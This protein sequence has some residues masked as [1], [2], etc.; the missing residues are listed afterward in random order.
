MSKIYTSADQIDF[1]LAEISN[2][3]LPESLLMVEP[4]YFSVDYV[5]NPHMQGNIGKVDKQKAMNEWNS[6]KK[7]YESA[8]LT[9]HPISGAKGLPDMVFCAN[10]SLPFLSEDGKKEV[11]MIFVTRHFAKKMLFILSC[12]LHTTV[13]A[14][15][16][17][18]KTISK[19]SL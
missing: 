12:S 4:T 2:M 8:G 11:L 16:H 3:P 14:A 17:Q 18:S 7:V 13:P 10:Q 5:I 19:G 6:I 1:T 9:V 15:L